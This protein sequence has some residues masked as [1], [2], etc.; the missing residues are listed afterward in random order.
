MAWY[1]S[2]HLLSK[3]EVGQED[4]RGG[5]TRVQSQQEKFVTGTRVLARGAKILDERPELER[6]ENKIPKTTEKLEDRKV[7][8][9]LPTRLNALFTCF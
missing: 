6:G 8:F 7:V 4:R 2:C 5:L 3:P 9:L 1:F